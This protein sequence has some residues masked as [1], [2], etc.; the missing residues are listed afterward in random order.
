MEF[1]L[2]DV[3]VAPN[4]LVFVDPFAVKVVVEEAQGELVAIVE[5]LFVT[6]FIVPKEV[7]KGVAVGLESEELFPVSK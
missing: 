3:V 2:E 7:L 4:G 6:P 1:V 5:L